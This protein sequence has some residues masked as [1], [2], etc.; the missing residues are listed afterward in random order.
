[1]KNKLQEILANELHRLILVAVLFSASLLIVIGLHLDK[2]ELLKTQ[3]SHISRLDKE[4]KTLLKK[5]AASDV[6]ADV[7]RNANKA[8]RK[9]I[10]KQQQQIINQEKAL[11]FFKQ[12]MAAGTEKQGLDLNAYTI[13]PLKEVRS[14]YFRFTF[15]QYAKTHSL[16][17]ASVN[18]T[19]TGQQTSNTDNNSG[20]IKKE[21]S[22]NFNEL[23]GNQKK[24]IDSLRFKYY[25][26]LEGQLHLP[27]D[28]IPEKIIIDAQVK[29]RKTKPW[30]KE[31]P[32][33]TEQ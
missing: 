6:E 20:N 15:V 24:P 8:L 16:L 17:K 4:K 18:I 3:S 7:L 26:T 13:T 21:I 19:L 14:Y 29:R 25:K 2:T 27:E 11:D 9:T 32:W 23:L 12:L 30:H 33:Q 22:Y 28:F 10:D 1:M 5:L 31:L